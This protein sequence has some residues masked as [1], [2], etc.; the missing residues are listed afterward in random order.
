[1]KCASYKLEFAHGFRSSGQ[2]NS[3]GENCE[4][5]QIKVRP[6]K[7]NRNNNSIDCSLISF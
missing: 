4:L 3:S 7:A 5:V 1:M 2:R 6:R